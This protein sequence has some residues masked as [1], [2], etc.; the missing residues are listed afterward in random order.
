MIFVFLVYDTLCAP[1]S[2]N[3]VLCWLDLGSASP[4]HWEPLDG[5]NLR[6][7]SSELSRPLSRL[8]SSQ[9]SYLGGH[10]NLNNSSVTEI[11]CI[12]CSIPLV[13]FSRAMCGVTSSR[14]A[15]ARLNCPSHVMGQGSGRKTHLAPPSALRFLSSISSHGLQFLL[16]ILVGYQGS[17]SFF[18]S[19]CY[20]LEFGQQFSERL[21][22]PVRYSAIFLEVPSKCLLVLL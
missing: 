6:W 3:S 21:L 22:L 5:V 8:A 15:S 13:G 18:S 7:L 14:W 17:A 1:A 19:H 10:L 12:S 9:S 16:Q 4:R 11:H 20:L 2:W